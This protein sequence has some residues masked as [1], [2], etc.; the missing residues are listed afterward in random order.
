MVNE[1]GSR[2]ASLIIGLAHSPGIA[3]ECPVS[4]AKRGMASICM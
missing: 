4:N 3:E 2:N 1:G